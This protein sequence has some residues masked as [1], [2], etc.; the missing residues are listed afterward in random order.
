[1]KKNDG[2][3]TEE[4]AKRKAKIIYGDI[5]SPQNQAKIRPKTPKE[6][7]NKNNTTNQLVSKLKV[8]Y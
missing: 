1:M 5:K 4:L 7:L 2:L 6:N 3:Q 8:I